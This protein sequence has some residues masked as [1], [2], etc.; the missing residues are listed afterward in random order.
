MSSQ[1]ATI[2]L[3]DEHFCHARF[4]DARERLDL[5]A[6]E[7][8]EKVFRD[9]SGIYTLEDTGHTDGTV[10]IRT[11]RPQESYGLDSQDSPTSLTIGDMQRIAAGGVDTS[12]AGEVRRLRDAGENVPA[13]IRKFGRN[14]AGKP[15]P[16]LVGN[17]VDRS[18]TRFENWSAASTANKTVTVLP[19]RVL[20]IREMDPQ[21]LRGA[22]S[23]VF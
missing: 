12:K 6:R 8:V 15:Q 14:L 18:M 4:I 1:K 22:S 20:G 2:H 21:D 19:D 16:D 10:K 3:L 9:S 7:S 17:A 23:F 5:L 11:L 13:S